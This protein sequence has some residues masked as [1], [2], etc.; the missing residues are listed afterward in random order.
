MQE[1]KR[2]QMLTRL[3]SISS[4]LKS[5]EISEESIQSDIAQVVKEIDEYVFQT[6]MSLEEQAEKSI[7]RS[8]KALWMT[9]VQ[10]EKR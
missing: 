5:I 3:N 10:K 6:V 9:Y 7:W 1:V 8:L 4:S 2:A